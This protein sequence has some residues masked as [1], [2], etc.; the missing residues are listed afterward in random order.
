[1]CLIS[2]LR[3]STFTFGGKTGADA[4]EG[5]RSEVVWSSPVNET[6]Q[7]RIVDVEV[8]LCGSQLFCDALLV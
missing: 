4:G 2:F 8:S 1:M 5:Q 3:D 7:R 6:L